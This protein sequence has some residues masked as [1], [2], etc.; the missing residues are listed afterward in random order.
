[1]RCASPGGPQAGTGPPPAVA[2]ASAS[3]GRPQTLDEPDRRGPLLETHKRTATA[4]LEDTSGAGGGAA[5]GAGAASAG[6]PASGPAPTDS[7]WALPLSPAGGQELQQ[8]WAGGASGGGRGGASGGEQQW[9]PAEWAEWEQEQAVGPAGPGRPTAVFGS[10]DDRVAITTILQ[11]GRPGREGMAAGEEPDRLHLFYK[12]QGLACQEDGT[13]GPADPAAAAVVAVAAAGSEM[14]VDAPAEAA[15]GS[16]AGQ[17]GVCGAAAVGADAGEEEAVGGQNVLES[18]SDG[19]ASRLGDRDISHLDL[20][21][22]LEGGLPGLGLEL[23][24]QPAEAPA[25]FGGGGTAIT[26]PRNYQHELTQQAKQENVVA[27][28]ETGAGKT[29]IAVMLMKELATPRALKYAV[30]TRVEAGYQ[31][32]LPSLRAQLRLELRA[33][34]DRERTA[35][36]AGAGAA[37]GGGAGGEARK[38]GGDEVE[39]AHLEAAGSAW[40]GPVVPVVQQVRRVMRD[41]M[42]RVARKQFWWNPQWQAPQRGGEAASICAAALRKGLL[43]RLS[44]E[45][46]AARGGGGDR[47]GGGAAETS[48]RLRI[49]AEHKLVVFLVPRVPLVFQQ[50]QVIRI[51]TELEVGEYCGEMSGDF[52]NQR[53]WT[54]EFRTKD[55]LVLTPQ[56]LLNIM[57]HGFVSMERFSLLIFDECHHCVARHPYNLIMQE[58]Y[59]PL[60]RPGRRPKVFGMT[61]SPVTTMILGDGPAEHRRA[62]LQ[63]EQNLDCR[64]VTVGKAAQAEVE[65]AAPKPQEA[66][67]EHQPP[68]METAWRYSTFEPMLLRLLD[69]M[70]EDDPMLG[71]RLAGGM[72]KR[73]RGRAKHYEEEDDD[74][75]FEDGVQRFLQTVRRIDKDNQ[76]EQAGDGPPLASSATG[77]TASE[78][79]GD[80]TAAGAAAGRS[81]RAGPDRAPAGLDAAQ[82]AAGG[83]TGGGFERRPG[84]KPKE[85]VEPAVLQRSRLDQLREQW[86][87]DRDQQIETSRAEWFARAAS[88][89]RHLLRELGPWA[90]HGFLDRLLR[91]QAAAS[92]KLRSRRRQEPDVM[93]AAVAGGSSGAPAGADGMGAMGPLPKMESEA[94]A[95]ASASAVPGLGRT[96]H[97]TEPPLPPSQAAP[98]GEAAAAAGVVHAGAAG[99]APMQTGWPPS[100]EAQAESPPAAAGELAARTNAGV[101]LPVVMPEAV[102][103]AASELPGGL[104]INNSATV[105][106]DRPPPTPAEVTP[107]ARALLELLLVQAKRPGFSGIVFVH[108]RQTALWLAEVLRRSPRMVEAGS[109]LNPAAMVGHGAAGQQ[110]NDMCGDTMQLKQQQA[111]LA[112]FRAGEVN[113]LVATALVEEGL[114]VRACTLVVR[115]NECLTLASYV[116]SRGRAR[117]PCSLYILM[118]EADSGQKQIMSASGEAERLVRAAAVEDRAVLRTKGRELNNQQFIG[119]DRVYRVDATGAMAT[120]NSCVSLVT[121]YCSHLPKDKFCYMAPVY[122]YQK[123]RCPTAPTGPGAAAGEQKITV[124]G[125]AAEDA[126][127]KAWDEGAVDD[128]SGGSDDPDGV[129]GWVVCTLELP[130]NAAVHTV[131]SAPKPS[132]AE[133]K[134]R[135]CLDACKQ[136]HQCGAL[137][138]HLLPARGKDKGGESDQ[139]PDPSGQLGRIFARRRPYTLRPPEVLCAPPAC[140]APAKSVARQPSV[141]CWAYRFWLGHDFNDR[142][143]FCM[144]THAALPPVPCFE[145]GVKSLDNRVIQAGIWPV[146]HLLL[147]PQQLAAARRFNT[148][149]FCALTKQTPTQF[150]YRAG[151]GGTSTYVVLPLAAAAA[152][153]PV[154]LGPGQGEGSLGPE[155]EAAAMDPAAEAAWE[156][157]AGQAV[158]GAVW[159]V[160][161]K[162]LVDQVVAMAE[163]AS[164]AGADTT[165]G[166]GGADGWLAGKVVATRYNMQKYLVRRVRWDLSPLSA[167]PNDVGLSREDELVLNQPILHGNIRTVKPLAGKGGKG[168]A[169]PPTKAPRRRYAT[170]AEY[171]SRNWQQEVAPGQ[172]LLEVEFTGVR[173][174]MPNVKSQARR[175][176]LMLVP[177]LCLLFPLPYTALFIPPLLIRVERRLQQAQLRAAIGWSTVDHSLFVQALTAPFG[178]PDWNYERLENLAR[179]PVIIYESLQFYSV[180]SDHAD[181]KCILGLFRETRCSSTRY[182]STSSS[183]TRGCTRGSS[184]RCG[185]RWCP[186]SVLSLPFPEIFTVFSLPF[187]DIPLAF[188]SPS[189]FELVAAQAGGFD[190]DTALPRLRAAAAQGMHNR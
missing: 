80:A 144:L 65:A 21:A 32:D 103:H 15:V 187:L 95:A 60:Q 43:D 57:R 99:A 62:L 93:A 46:P 119:A 100:A 124:L 25:D 49:D 148:A 145:L 7:S 175:E 37:A 94:A 137:N 71:V 18:V 152:G 165:G 88:S 143:A 181:S 114:D 157:A 2:A 179:R 126:A 122:R 73:Q 45:A 51:N 86:Q 54:E 27:F 64:V 40:D 68:P 109:P 131:V 149:L 91:G 23:G 16:G 120:V 38:F 47:G 178:N 97:Q 39:A 48:D 44:V 24:L 72:Q 77:A 132:L 81:D 133:A 169:P 183:N 75:D 121:H 69:K 108:R 136:L 8:Q 180:P 76:A 161:D 154:A 112:Q 142:R 98:T 19:I 117:H 116:Q 184:R 30:A 61:A 159:E 28:L 59:W 33:S 110:S 56:L 78:G 186:F 102:L 3:G 188:S 9:S 139:L 31:H 130:L 134:R 168:G 162:T 42:N 34:R 118:A 96:L 1:M 151:E 106:G 163:P 182:R 10:G 66:E 70:M 55:V 140:L 190:G 84:K 123:V 5:W 11:P 79:R 20:E 176:V 17:S 147:A 52:W 104:E 172:P 6:T 35:A 158:T 50:A 189:D 101:G 185:C 36:A 160:F 128:A 107:K 29:Y 166:H 41:L 105:S 129:G 150:A 82:V 115:Y 22:I 111:V 14:A 67:L 174:M 83:G 63:L 74:S 12:A 167:F 173:H 155:A 177:E 13:Y 53:S 85:G 58:F 87:A 89:A 26:G 135:A 146:G 125:E 164:W 127:D 170:Y 153:R 4:A 92:T 113:L 90:A 138:D 156:A 141:R 171:Y